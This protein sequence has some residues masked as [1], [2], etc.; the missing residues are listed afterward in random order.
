MGLGVTQGRRKSTRGE[1]GREPCWALVRV[2]GRGECRERGPGVCPRKSTPRYHATSGLLPNPGRLPS[3]LP[4]DRNVA[5]RPPCPRPCLARRAEGSMVGVPARLS[6]SPLGV[7][8]SQQGGAWRACRRGHPSPSL[9][10]QVSSPGPQE[11]TPSGLSTS[12]GLREQKGRHCPVGRFLPVFCLEECLSSFRDLLVMITA[13]LM[14]YGHSVSLKLSMKGRD[15]M[16]ELFLS[17]GARGEDTEET[18]VL[19]LQCSQ[20]GLHRASPESGKPGIGCSH[21]DQAVL[22]L[23]VATSARVLVSL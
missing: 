23:R 12:L 9:G 6:V 20:A 18:R 16:S 5:W 21:T 22:S 2:V 3:S 17:A 10:S 8:G 15:G 11:S 7:V 1:G 4:W 14:V 19:P 13:I